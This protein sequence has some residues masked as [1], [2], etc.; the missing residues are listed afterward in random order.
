[1]TTSQTCYRGGLSEGIDSIDVIV[2]KECESHGHLFTMYHGYTG[3]PHGE[4]NKVMVSYLHLIN[5]GVYTQ[6]YSR[7]RLY[8]GGCAY[9]VPQGSLLSVLD[10]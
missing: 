3:D 9:P 8:I 7:I 6:L 4:I 1:M 2:Y 10:R 5:Y